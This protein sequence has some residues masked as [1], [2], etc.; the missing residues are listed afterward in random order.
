MWAAGW[1]LACISLSGQF[2]TPLYWLIGRFTPFLQPGILKLLD[3]LRIRA[4]VAQRPAT[5]RAH[6]QNGLFDFLRRFG[7][8]SEITVRYMAFCI[9]LPS[10][11]FRCHYMGTTAGNAFPMADVERS[12]GVERMTLQVRRP[13]RRKAG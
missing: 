3:D 8:F 11:Q 5:T 2:V 4:A 6:S 7:L 12:F 9:H 1:R 13:H 10:H